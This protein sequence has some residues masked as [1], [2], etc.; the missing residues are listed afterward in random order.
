M[1]LINKRVLIIGIAKS[2]IAAAK[3]CNKLGANVIMYDGKDKKSLEGILST[4]SEYN[5][6]YCFGEFDKE[7]YKNL[8]YIILSPGVPT[9]LIFINDAREMNIKII[10]EIELAYNF[11]KSDIIAITGTNGKTTTTSLVGEIMKAYYENAYIVG[12]IGNPFT[13]IVLESKEDDIVVAEISSFQLETIA[14]FRPKISAILNITE[15]HLDRHKTFEKY[16]LT[17][18]SISKNQDQND[19]C[20]LNFDDVLCRKYAD[21]ISAKIIWF[22]TQEAVEG[23]YYKGKKFIMNLNGI[24]KEIMRLEDI[25]LLGKHNIENILSAIGISLCKNVPLEIIKKTISSFKGVEHRIEFVAEINGIKYYNDSKATNP[26]A[27]IKGITSMV[28]PTILIAGGYNKGSIYDEWINSFN[29]IVKKL[30]LFGETKYLIEEAAKRCGFYEI[31]MV[32]T[33]DEALHY[34]VNIASKGDNILLSPACASWDMFEN[35]EERG[36]MF[37]QL[38]KSLSI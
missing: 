18:L 15:D 38:I 32:N 37:K 5:F 24:H 3:L 33:L 30:V 11:C 13:D 14:K 23:V 4:L 8:D 22:S 2:G 31:V 35:Y 25:K 12:N 21:R 16:I 20:I 34:A 10:G 7:L 27:A 9:D 6:E 26:D 19:Y 28:S 17:K 29:G 1:R 36:K